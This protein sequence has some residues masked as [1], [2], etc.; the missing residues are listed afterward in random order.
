MKQ[1]TI[2]PVIMCGGSGTRLWPL[3]L[4]KAP[5]QYHTLT[6]DKTML[7]ETI[8]RMVGTASLSVAAPS[9]ICAK[10]HEKIVYEQSR[11]IGKDPLHVILEPMGR[12][13]APV[14]VIA[15]EIIGKS[16]P[17]GLILLLPADHFIKDVAEFWRCIEQGISSASLGKLVTLGIQPTSPATGYG[18]I[19]K[20]VSLSK[21]VYKVARFVEKPDT[22]TAQSYLDSGKHFWN[23]GIFLFSPEAMITSFKKH[24]PEILQACRH[25]LQNSEHKNATILL[26]AESF[27]KCP[28]DSIDYAIMEHADNIVLVAPVDVGW[29]DI[30]SWQALDTFE[31]SVPNNPRLSGGDNVEI[32]DTVLLDC[33]NTYVR[34][35]GPLVTGVGLK[36]LTII[37]TKDSILILPKSRD[38]DVKAIVERLK[39][40]KRDECL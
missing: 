37:A 25:T 4:K 22:S 30:G 20:G 18:Y 1:K 11:A 21:S 36:D 31:K 7:Q 34:S 5:K 23:A 32:G 2:Y 6:S 29:N 28:P 3:S 27:A 26:D 33:Q 9:F 24:A 16:D 12:N 38:Q 14:A 35:D 19:R 8:V 40:D 13:T 17:D 10:D 39:S 15:A